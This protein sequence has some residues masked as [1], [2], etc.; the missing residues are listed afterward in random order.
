MP[1]PLSLY[2]PEDA[3]GILSIAYFH[4]MARLGVEGLVV[5]EPS[6][7]FV[8][9]GYFDNVPAIIDL[10]WC[11]AQGIPV[12]RREV[13]GGPVLLGPGQVFYNLVVKRA[14]NRVPAIVDR[15]YRH[16]S[17]A[18]IATYAKF[19]VPVHYQ[20][21]NDLVTASGRK[22]AGQGAADI[23]GCFCYV[24]SILCRFD[25]E[26]MAH[27]LRAPDAGFRGRLHDQMDRNLTW[28]DRETGGAVDREQVA[29]T[30]I[31][32]F[33][34][35]LGPLEEQLL[36][37]AVVDLA[38]ELALS[39]ASE[40]TLAL[41]HRRRHEAIKIREGVYLSYASKNDADGD[42]VESRS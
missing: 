2:R 16:L 4:A 37:Q 5:I 41:E 20:P 28:L 19:G 27:V 15:A 12:M 1:A 17:R 18:P 14:H 13:G 3:S 33:R 24:G 7:H 34:D 6:A 21:I 8:S 35:L 36:P 39:L 26:T 30:L 22:I 9:A 40:E 42:G 11:R 38:H 23:D 31:A 29:T 10:D 25:V 32:D